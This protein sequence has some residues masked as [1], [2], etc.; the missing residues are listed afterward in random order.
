MCRL[1]AYLGETLALKTLLLEP[2]H[3]LYVQ[4]WQPKELRYA[5]L[6]ADGFG[7][8][9]YLPDGTAAAYRNQ[10]PIWNDPNLE[11]LG[12]ALHAPLWLAI[13]RSATAD[14]GAS[15][16]NVQPFRYARLMF[17]HN[18]YIE[19]FNRHARHAIAAELEPEI[20]ENVR[21]LTDSEYLFGLV[22]RFAAQRDGNL[23]AALADAADWCRRNLLDKAALLN[24]I[25]TDGEQICALRFALHAEAPTLYYTRAAPPGFPADSQLIASERLTDGGD[26]REVPAGQLLTLRRGQAAALKPLRALD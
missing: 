15:Q 20:L 25:I 13:V 8:G 5:K 21:G 12:A 7:F 16:A 14:Y 24:V 26:W 17:V 22:C 10:A 1:A 18:G 11:N 23:E 19:D 3:S 2:N 6:N 4:S 9:W